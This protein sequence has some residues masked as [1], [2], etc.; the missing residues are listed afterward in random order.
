MTQFFHLS[1]AE[2]DATQC[3]IKILRG[4]PWAA[5]LLKRMV[6]SRGLSESNKSSL[7]EARVALALHDRGVAPGYEHATGV[8]DTTV[9]FNSGPW[10]VELYSLDESDALRAATWQDGPIFGRVLTTYQPLDQGEADRANWQREQDLA[11]LDASSMSDALKFA[12]RN[13]VMA[14]AEAER[15]QREQ[16]FKQSPAAEIVK[17]IE[18]VVGKAINDGQPAKFPIP[19][20]LHLSVLLVDA[21]ALGVS[22]P[23]RYDCDL[24]AYGANAVPEHI[25]RQFVAADGKARP[26]L[27]VFDPGNMM[28]GAQHFR[29]RVHFLGIVSE[30]TYARDELHHAIRFYANPH[31]FASEHAARAA[32]EDFPLFSQKA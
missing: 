14:D 4:L 28:K 5:P 9:D 27:G 32:L 10:L 21:R 24:I 26:I 15:Q 3:A 20:G 17:A 8:G 29:E 30:K 23:D 7:F 22:G 12:I 13:E 2:A 19:T 16:L 11:L 18:R 6:D 1:N 31:L 25:E